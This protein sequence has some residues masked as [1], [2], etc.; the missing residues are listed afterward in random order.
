MKFLLHDTRQ[1]KYKIL[2]L[3]SKKKVFFGSWMIVAEMVIFRGFGA[4]KCLGP[5]GVNG[6][7]S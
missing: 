1:G 4:R 3:D 6:N 7:E 5:L 2:R